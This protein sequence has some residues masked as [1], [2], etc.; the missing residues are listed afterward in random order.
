MTQVDA[1]D[2]PLEPLSGQVHHEL[3]PA[4]LARRD[5]EYGVADDEPEDVDDI[6]GKS[7]PEHSWPGTGLVLALYAAAGL[8]LV[9]AVSLFGDVRWLGLSRFL[10]M[11]PMMLFPGALLL[12]LARAIQQ[13][14]AA[15]L[16]VAVLGLLASL[17][18]SLV[19]L[20]RAEDLA[21]IVTCMVGAPLFVLWIGYLWARRDD[22]S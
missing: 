1:F 13:F 14:K 11:L 15:G 20:G 5:A 2:H 22:F 19:R 12:W 6:F 8:S 3:S 10:A 21:T 18:F 4:E 16:G 7:P 9:H 17:V